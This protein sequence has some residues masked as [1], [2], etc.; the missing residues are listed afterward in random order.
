MKKTPYIASVS[1]LLLAA[2]GA[3]SD[4]GQHESSAGVEV[5]KAATTSQP[6]SAPETSNSAGSASESGSASGSA[7]A[8]AGEAKPQPVAERD[9][10]DAR[11]AAVEAVAQ[12]GGANG[13]VIAEDLEGNG[14]DV[15]VLVG[16]TVYDVF[17]SGSATIRD[18]ERADRD[19][20]AAAKVSVNIAAAI[21]AALA[22]TPGKLTEISYDDG[23]WDATIISSSDSAEYELRIDSSSVKVVSSERD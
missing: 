1:I 14:W 16:D 19:D 17:V 22:N 11:D 12:A 20:Q 8:P 4:Q 13:I 6:S 18:Q 9:I 15:D 5:T 10:A 7:S 23:M 3:C 21:D 2:L